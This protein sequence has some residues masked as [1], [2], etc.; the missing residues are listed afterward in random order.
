MLIGAYRPYE[1]QPNDPK[2]EKFDKALEEL[3]H[4]FPDTWTKIMLGD[5]NAQDKAVK[6]T[7]SSPPPPPPPQPQPQPPP[8][9]NRVLLLLYL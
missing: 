6:R 9:P 7:R 4:S 5:L 3:W 2:A 1:K 8:Q